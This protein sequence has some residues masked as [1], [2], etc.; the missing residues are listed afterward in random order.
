M[1]C[2]ISFGPLP[3]DADPEDA[4]AIAFSYLDCLFKN[5]QIYGEPLYSTGQSR[6]TAFAYVPRPDSL[7]L[8]YHSSYALSA[9][10]RVKALF[11]R[12][13]SITRFL[14][15][16]RDDFPSFS[17]TTE[18]FLHP[19]KFEGQSPLQCLETAEKYPSYLVRISD[20][21]RDELFFWARDYQRLDGIWLRSDYLEIDAY[22]QLACPNSELSLKGRSLA[23]A[24]E[25]AEG[26]PVFYY[27]LRYYGRF[28][29]ESDRRCP[30]CNQDWWIG[31]QL[32]VPCFHDFPFKCRSCR[33]VSSLGTETDYPSL[34]L[35]GDYHYPFNQ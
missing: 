16:F 9:L 20:Q 1:L 5:G 32:E 26:K 6:V 28:Q 7:A 31:H 30:V 24:I 10:E 25:R 15:D 35:I 23:R 8:E 33:L 21:E 18:Y 13:P 3:Q 34:A 12:S 19:A 27:L 22:R 2:E 17:Q 4:G 14:D 11:G 29:G